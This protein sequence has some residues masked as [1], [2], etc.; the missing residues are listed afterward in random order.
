MLSGF[1]FRN[2]LS[3]TVVQAVPSWPEFSLVYPEALIISTD[4]K[5]SVRNLPHQE[6]LTKVKNAL[7]SVKIKEVEIESDDY[8]PK[9]VIEKVMV[10]AMLMTQLFSNHLVHRFECLTISFSGFW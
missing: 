4:S 8:C 7:F 10:Y 3:P 9:S 1:D 2:P 5:M 6:R